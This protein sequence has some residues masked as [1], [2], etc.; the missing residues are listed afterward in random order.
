MGLSILCSILCVFSLAEVAL[1][2]AI[3]EAVFLRYGYPAQPD[4][5]SIMVSLHS[6]QSKT[7]G[8]IPQCIYLPKLLCLHSLLQKKLDAIMKTTTHKKPDHRLFRHSLSGLVIALAA[9][10]SAQMASAVDNAELG[11]EEVLVTASKRPQKL[12]DIAGSVSVVTDVSGTHLTLADIA[13]QIPGFSL[14]QSGPRNPDGLVIRGMRMEGVGAN[15]LGGDGASVVSYLDNSPL[16]GYFVPPTINLKD[17]ERL[18]VLRGPQGTLYGHSAIG[19]LVR[20]TSAKP[21]LAR[22]SAH[23]EAGLSQTRASSDLNY[24]THLVL[25]QPLITDQLGMRL[26]A[27]RELNQ[28]FVDNPYL[29]TGPQKDINDA[30]A[31]VAR[32]SLAWQPQ[33]ALSFTLSHHFQRD[34]VDDRQATNRDFTGDDYTA[35]SR[36]LQPMKSELNLTSL[37]VNYDF[38]WANLEASASRYDYRHRARADQTDLFYMLDELYY[39]GFYTAYEDFSAYTASDF[40]VDKDS[41]ELRLISS[42]DQRLR[43]LAGLFYT[44]DELEGWSGDFVP[45]FAEFIGMHRP[46][47]LDYYGSQA[48]VLRETSAYVEVSYDLTSTWEATLGWRHFRLDDD[49]QTCFAYPI[50]DGI[51]GDE[52]PLSCHVGRDDY[53]DN[54]AKFSTRYAL[55][56]SH[57]IYLTVAEGFRRGGAN[58]LPAEIDFPR[59]YKPDQ[60]VNYEVGTHS[61]FLDQ[62]LQ[63]SAAI[64]YVD[65]KDVHVRGVAADRYAI[66]VNAGRARSQGAEVSLLAVLSPAWTLKASYSVTDAELREDIPAIDG[67]NDAFAGDRLP[68]SARDEWHLGVDYQQPLGRAT[69]E[70]GLA[71]NHRGSMTTQLNSG[72]DNYEALSGHTLANARLGVSWRNWRGGI[73]AHNI[74]DTRAVTGRRSTLWFGE[75]GR[76]EYITRPR[77]LGMFVSYTY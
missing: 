38:G 65:W 18:E 55:S 44:R 48:E 72:F 69:L 12:S 22:S 33:E 32:L 5:I 26:L 54:L 73:F 23:L 52:L 13:G 1:F 75:Q 4:E 7:S 61:Y 64:F 77:T 42:S 46:D 27:G 28:G 58:A 76:F 70:A 37:D 8:L 30:D 39:G 63:L 51:E 71:F 59:G 21:D 25:N 53:R 10:G 35:S 24:D 60:V 34:E 6:G 50:G 29:L 57:K 3:R 56:D 36:Y 14:V 20:Y 41:F 66:T 2:V 62:R 74:A 17:M 16:Q 11:I 15:D 45:G 31:Q 40:E 43:W 68:G 9:S 19:G 47:A 49:L 67:E